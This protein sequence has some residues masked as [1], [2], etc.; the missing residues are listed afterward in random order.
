MHNRHAQMFSL[1]VLYDTVTGQTPLAWTVMSN[2]HFD[3]PK[4]WVQLSNM[5]NPVDWP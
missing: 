2:P 1:S 4:L 5:S 3:W